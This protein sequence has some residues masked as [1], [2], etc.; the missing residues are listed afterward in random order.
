MRAAL[1]LLALAPALAAQTP[2]NSPLHRQLLALAHQSGGKAYVACS[3]P[4]TA[5]DCDL[6]PDAH[7]PMQSVFKFPLAM[8]I[9]HAVEEN[10]FTLDQPIR[11]L[12]EDRIL[13]RTHS[14]IQDQYP[15]ANVDIPLR[16][17]LQQVITT[18]DNAAS[19]VL[20]R[21][22]GG[23]SALDS[24]L[25][26]IGISGIEVRDGEQAM[27]ANNLLQYRNVAEP[28]AM[29]AL[30]RRLADRSPL[31]PEHTTLL[32]RWM[33]DSTT[34]AGR[35]RA[36]LPLNTV[37]AHKTGS[38][39]T[40]HH[41]TAA[42]NDVALITLPDGRTLALAIFITDSHAG[43]ATIEASIARIAEAIYNEALK[44]PATK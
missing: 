4:G 31:S 28:A 42:T 32:L 37:V 1:I 44:T 41:I 19:E 20:L 21:I 5:L 36:L 18:S 10:K 35:I 29:V 27:A 22:L 7:A 16:E 3:L 11:F 13:P 14:A 2:H 12:P 38:S 43:A 33:S 34:G 30:L 17:L 26:S 39:G 6:H 23:P 9:L 25:K 15:N 8:A 24:Y 40:A